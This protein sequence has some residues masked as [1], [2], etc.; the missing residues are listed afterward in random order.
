MKLQPSNNG[1]LPVGAN[2][3]NDS[4][5]IRYDP[6]NDVGMNQLKSNGYFFGFTDRIGGL[7]N[8][9]PTFNMDSGTDVKAK[10]GFVPG[11]LLPTQPVIVITLHPI[12][13]VPSTMTIMH[14]V[15]QSGSTD[16]VDL[17]LVLLAIGVC[18]PAPETCPEDLNK[19][20]VV[21]NTDVGLVLLHFGL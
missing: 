12:D 20:G 4:N 11:S 18:P 3:N 9:N 6:Y 10:L 7:F 17:S 15:N 13:Q 16:S 19:D 1:T 8:P 5:M 14:D 21:D 2:L